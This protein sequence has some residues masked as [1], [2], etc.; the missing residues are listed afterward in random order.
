MEINPAGKN[1]LEEGR[2]EFLNTFAK[3]AK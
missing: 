3:K 1:F 2:R